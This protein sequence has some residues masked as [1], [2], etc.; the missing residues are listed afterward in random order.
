M[1]TLPSGV[2]LVSI[3]FLRPA[4]FY[5]RFWIWRPSFEHQKDFNLPEQRAAR[6]ALMCISTAV[7][8]QERDF[9]RFEGFVGYSGV[10]TDSVL[11][12]TGP[13][14]SGQT[15]LESAAGFESA[16]IGN[17]NRTLGIKGDVSAHFGRYKE[18]D[19]TVPCG[20]PS[21][22]TQTANSHTR[23][24]NFLVGPELKLH[25]HA[26]LT[27]F[28]DVLF[29]LVHT[30]TFFRTNGSS[31]FCSTKVDLSATPDVKVILSWKK[32]EPEARRSEWRR[33][34]HSKRPKRGTRQI[35]GD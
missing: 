11:I 12:K 17:V 16:I 10:F 26:R 1:D 21:C 18:E 6:R 19:F 22:P 25:N 9:P 27:P 8:A 4:R 13:G 24:F 5:P 34:I 20:L 2:P 35:A 29:G 23:L 32:S 7:S 30:S 31:V 3:H 14:A 33:Q 28:A 15:D